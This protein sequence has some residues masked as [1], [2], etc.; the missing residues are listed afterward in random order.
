MAALDKGQCFK[1]TLL[2]LY[3]YILLFKYILPR[4]RRL[5]GNYLSFLSNQQSIKV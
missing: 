2:H 4:L 5:V 1:A 3:F